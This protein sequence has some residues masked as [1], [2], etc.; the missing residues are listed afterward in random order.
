MK[1]IVRIRGGLGNQL[2]AY[3]AARRLAWANKAELIID[4]VSG[5]QFDH[6]YQQRY[7][8][9]HFNVKVPLASA[10]ERLEP[11]SRARRYL[12]RLAN[13]QLPFEQRSYVQQEGNAFEPRLLK[14]KPCNYLYI[15]GYWQSERYFQDI[16]DVIRSDLSITPPLDDT[17]LQA[18]NKIQQCTAIAVHVRFFDKPTIQGNNNATADYYERALSEM[19]KRIPNAHYF[20]FSDDVLAARSLLGLP[21][22][23]MTPISHNQGDEYAYADL[24]LMTQCKHFIIANST[25]SWWGAWLST[26]QEK[27]IIAPGFVSEGSKTAWGFD[28]LLPEGWIKI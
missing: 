9:G 28:G 27:I 6:V 23:R 10:S 13:R 7:Q 11:F 15:E 1:V 19:D 26:C 18:A 17:N 2:F 5:F 22:E 14:I 4:H 21:D 16:E 20:L 25:F 8:L 12:K 24:W 3:A